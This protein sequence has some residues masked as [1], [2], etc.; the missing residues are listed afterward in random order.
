MAYW[1][2]SCIDNGRKRQAFTVKAE[3]KVEAE[4][5]A[6]KKAK[7]NAKGDIITWNLTLSLVK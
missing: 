4:K 2:F 7:K 1:S 3:S 6:F 5:I